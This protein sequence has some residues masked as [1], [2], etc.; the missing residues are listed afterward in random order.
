MHLSITAVRVLV[1]SVALAV[2]AST[3]GCGAAESSV[4]AKR[5]A[6]AVND[7]AEFAQPSVES[8]AEGRARPGETEP[9]VRDRKI[10]YN[11]TLDIVVDS[12]D[13]VEEKVGDLVKEHQGFVANSSLGAKVGTRRRGSWV[14]RVPVDQ[15]KPFLNGVSAIGET[16]STESANDVTAEFVDIEARIASKQK[17]EERVLQ[18]LDRP[19]D[20]IQH[21]IE[22][23]KEL[24]RIREEIER[25]QGRLRLLSDQ[26][27]L[28]TVTIKIREERNYVAPEKTLTV[29]TRINTAW[30]NSLAEARRFCENAIVWLAGNL[31]GL[32]FSIFSFVIVALSAKWLLRWAIKFLDV[33]SSPQR[34]YAPTPPTD[35][36]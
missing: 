2:G 27:S 6:S 20:K 5:T 3:L 12:Y 8:M 19:D 31:I 32:V 35:E 18:L 13:G 24:A 7:E 25:M 23:E 4:D 1:A 28:S 21:V 22:V 26:T 30:N 11:A 17:L 9:A 14:V 10:V 36:A 16:T 15:Y 33:S 34:T 29:G